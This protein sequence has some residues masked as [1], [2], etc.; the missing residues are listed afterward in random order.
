M[1]TLNKDPLFLLLLIIS[2]IGIL[3]HVDMPN[4]L[5]LLR[6]EVLFPQSHHTSNL[7]DSVTGFLKRSYRIPWQILI[8]I[9]E[10][11]EQGTG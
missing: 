2:L 7:K 11:L 1:V 8:L 6:T 3:G 4:L 9:Q 10:E 5:K